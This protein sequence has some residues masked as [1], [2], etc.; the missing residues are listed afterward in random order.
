MTELGDYRRL[1]E[2][3]MIEKNERTVALLHCRVS[4][5]ERA[6]NLALEILGK[7]EPGDSR[8]VSN[9]FVAM[10]AV[11]AGH[12]DTGVMSIIDDALRAS[13]IVVR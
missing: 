5:L 11:S 2:R 13:A 4:R 3:P 12:E 9:E 7:F 1:V 10:A 8:A 6:L